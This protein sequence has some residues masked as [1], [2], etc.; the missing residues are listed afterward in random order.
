MK[1]RH[2][3]LSLIILSATMSA[4]PATAEPPQPHRPPAAV[5]P[6]LPPLP[7]FL[8]GLHLSDDQQDKLFVIMQEAMA[9]QRGRAREVRRAREELQQLA[10]AAELDEAKA[11]KLTDAIGRAQADLELQR[12]R[13]DQR[14]FHL[15]SAEQRQ[16]AANGVPVGTGDC[17][18]PPRP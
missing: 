7:P 13:T 4:L 5:M 18:P 9:S 17:P 1:S 14:I 3:I 16:Q 10:R 15:L 6:D 8:H 2:T 12:V 11:R